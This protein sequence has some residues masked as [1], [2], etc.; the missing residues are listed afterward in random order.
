MKIYA[1]YD[2]AT[3][4]FGQPF[5][6]KA[7]GQAVRSF[8]DECENPESQFAKHPGDFDLFYIGEYN[9]ENGTIT[10]QGTERVARASDFAK[11]E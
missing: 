8:R 5:F 2:H 6:V 4:A 10:Q 9:E 7:Q 1:I 3:E 11:G